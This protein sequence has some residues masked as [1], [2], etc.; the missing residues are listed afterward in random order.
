MIF[1]LSFYYYNKSNNS[2]KS[3]LFSD[4]NL[5][6]FE[7]EKFLIEEEQKDKL[8]HCTGCEYNSSLFE[9]DMCNKINKNNCKTCIIKDSCYSDS[10]CYSCFNCT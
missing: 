3:I 4:D 10:E 1:F 7:T 8:Y 9:C 6:L 5:D 2:S